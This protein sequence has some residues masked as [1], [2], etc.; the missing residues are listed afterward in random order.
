[1]M[2]GFV[3]RVKQRISS[4]NTKCMRT[5]RKGASRI[6]RKAIL[7]AGK[8]PLIIG[9]KG[10]PEGF[11]EMLIFDEF[12]N[13]SPFPNEHEDYFGYGVAHVLD[14]EAFAEIT[15]PDRRKYTEREPK[16]RRDEPYEKLAV[17]RRI[18]DEGF[19]TYGYY[20]DKHDPP[21]GW[22]EG[23]PRDRMIG[24][25]DYVM[26]HLV[27]NLYGNVYVV[28]DRHSSYGGRI[29][30]H[31]AQFTTADQKFEGDWYDSHSGPFHESLQT[32]DH[33]ASGVRAELQLKDDTRTKSMRTKVI[34]IDPKESVRKRRQ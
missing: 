26:G 22:I 18:G 2:F 28:V 4:A 29:P 5:T 6:R 13:P 11:D 14:N 10:I 21:S 9:R 31:V 30:R 33:V 27:E 32:I 25:F 24:V 15:G 16:A 17:A 12:G 23:K 3:T 7:C 34:K 19:E 20:V 1:M 8:K